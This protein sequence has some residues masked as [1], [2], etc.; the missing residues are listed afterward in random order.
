MDTEQA[1]PTLDQ[2]VFEGRNQEYGAFELRQNYNTTLLRA[3]GT[4]FLGFLL[5]LFGPLV[6]DSLASDGS[7]PDTELAVE[8][9]LLTLPPK[10]PEQPLLPKL[11]RVEPAAPA[12]A[13]GPVVPVPPSPNKVITENPDPAHDTLSM[14]TGGG[15]SRTGDPD[16]VA[17]G[18][19]G[20]L[21]GGT[22]TGTAG[23]GIAPEESI[24]FDVVEQQP[25]FPG[26]DAALYS[27]VSSKVKYP[28]Q[29]QKVERQGTV[30][31]EFIVNAD[32]SLSDHKII[33]GQGYGLDE[34]ALRVI[35]KSP[36]WIPGKNNGKP[37]RV[38]VQVPIKFR[39]EVE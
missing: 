22:E 9:T 32:G 34:E 27:F 7:Q 14:Q 4:A 1:I 23:G 37:V 11:P 35:Q 10:L 17:G 16:G 13:S 5:A 38:K 31:V 8:T 28:Y 24:V 15:G 19:E 21:P 20:G 6:V 12:V 26:G 2:L 18:L 33:K 25:S 30:F 29:A 3:F 36:N 39:L